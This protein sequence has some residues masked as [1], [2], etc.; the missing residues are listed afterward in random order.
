MLEIIVNYTN[1]YIDCIKDNFL[2]E[3]DAKHID[4]TELKA[5]I[6]LL[7]IA[8]VHKAGKINLEELWDNNG[9]GVEIFRLTMSLK[10]F[11]YK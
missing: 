2:R 7:Y 11:I 3:R 5:L 6:G 10:R 8:G 1:Q 4:K 9:F